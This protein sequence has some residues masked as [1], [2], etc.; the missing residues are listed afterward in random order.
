MYE[1]RGLVRTTVIYG[2]STS[3][4]TFCFYYP[5]FCN[6]FI[7]IFFSTF[8][9]FFFPFLF[10][11]SPFSYFPQMISLPLP[12][13]GGDSPIDPCHLYSPFSPIYWT[14]CKIFR[15]Y[16]NCMLDY[17]LFVGHDLVGYIVSRFWKFCEKSETVCVQLLF[18][19]SGTCRTC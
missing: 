2:T 11:Y 6:F 16:L 19:S 7:Y 8:P 18:W 9:F 5:S 15:L 14:T 12:P 17:I 3:I 4:Y 1:L 10:L 13:G